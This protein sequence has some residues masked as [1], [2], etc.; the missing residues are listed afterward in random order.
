MRFSLLINMKMPTIVGIFIF[1][2]KEN[3]M[4]SWVEH[5]KSFITLGPDVRI[6]SCAKNHQSRCSPFIHSVVFNNSVS[7]QWGPWSDCMDFSD[8]LGLPSLHMPKDMFSHSTATLDKSQITQKCVF[9][10]YAN[11]EVTDQPVHS[12][13]LIRVFTIYLQKY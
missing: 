7:W 1:I 10:N 2:S 11:S 4:L 5:E 3:F 12:C 9:R 8:N 13:T 6:C